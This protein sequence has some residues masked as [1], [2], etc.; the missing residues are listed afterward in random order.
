MS[1]KINS[2]FKTN[3]VIGLTCKASK[4]FTIIELVLV[5]VLL[6]ILSVTVVP[7]L[8]GSNGFEEY[9][10][11]AEVI[12]TLRSIQLR[13]MQQTNIGSDECHTVIITSTLLT[14]DDNCAAN[15][16]NSVGDALNKLFVEIDSDHSVSFSPD[17]SFS[18]DAM[19]RPLSCA[20]DCIIILAGNDNLRV[21]IE[22][23]G[24]IHAE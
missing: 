24:F 18:F 5:I 13:A 6:G 19:G 2:R 12:A 3:S 1:N 16:E 22:S 20:D 8:F 7:K 4:G 9:A 23:E 10:Y 14:V 21:T 17:M 15:S 11:Q